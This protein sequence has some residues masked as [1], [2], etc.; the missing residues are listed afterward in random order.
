MTNNI[1]HGFTRES[2]TVFHGVISSRGNKH[3]L[4]A[5]CY[6]KALTASEKDEILIC[7]RITKAKLGK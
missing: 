6:N 1:T 4:Y 7:S 5:Y 3:L 2:A